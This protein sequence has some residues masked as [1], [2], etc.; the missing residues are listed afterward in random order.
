[1]SDVSKVDFN[2][3]TLDIKDALGR[4]ITIPCIC[5]NTQDSIYTEVSNDNRTFVAETYYVEL[6]GN[7]FYT[8]DGSEIS[9]EDIVSNLASVSGSIF[10]SDKLFCPFIWFI[11]RYTSIGRYEDS[12]IA[13]LRPALLRPK[14]TYIIGHT[15]AL[16]SAILHIGSSVAEWRPY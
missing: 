15:P 14:Y 4:L 2:D 3:Q 9:G 7:T 11:D 10:L 16:Y 13:S 8:M 1:M 12:G 6:V 5:G